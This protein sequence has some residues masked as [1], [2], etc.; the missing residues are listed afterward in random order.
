MID[1]IRALTNLLAGRR[2][3]YCNL[4]CPK[5]RGDLPEGWRRPSMFPELFLVPTDKDCICPSCA[6]VVLK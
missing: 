5:Q 6:K 1:F 3:S 2:C 4:R